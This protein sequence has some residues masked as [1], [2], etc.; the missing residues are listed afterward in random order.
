MEKS[1]RDSAFHV[2]QERLEAVEHDLADLQQMEEFINCGY[3]DLRPLPVGHDDAYA[4]YAGQFT[5][6]VTPQCP[7]ENRA[8]ANQVVQTLEDKTCPIR[9]YFKTSTPITSVMFV[10][11]CKAVGTALAQERDTLREVV[12]MLSAG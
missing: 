11:I 5:V 9:E 4:N 2:L 3:L 8:A 12:G 10:N 6:W 1:D 7:P